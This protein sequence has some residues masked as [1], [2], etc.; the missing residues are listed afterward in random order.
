MILLSIFAFYISFIFVKPYQV[1]QFTMV[2]SKIK[3]IWKLGA[4]FWVIL[5]IWIFFF[6]Y[7][8]DK[9]L[10]LLVLANLWCFGIFILMNLI[11]PI[12]FIF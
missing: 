7:N 1:H 12:P 5:F 11:F 9:I 3:I 8:K 2:I 6:R 10:I 4:A